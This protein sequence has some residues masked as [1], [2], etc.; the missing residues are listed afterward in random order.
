MKTVRVVRSTTSALRTPLS[1]SRIRLCRRASASSR[2]SRGFST[3]GLRLKKKFVFDFPD[4]ALDA[5]L[6]RLRDDHLL[7]VELV[8]D[9]GVHLPGGPHPE[10]NS[11]GQQRDDGHVND[12]NDGAAG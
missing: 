9:D 8:R 4:F 12:G 5:G 11:G 10:E 1:G 2:A 3:E 7:R 6:G